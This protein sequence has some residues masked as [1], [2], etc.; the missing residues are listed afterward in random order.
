M[1]PIK[2]PSTLQLVILVYFSQD[3]LL[4]LRHFSG[5]DDSMVWW[6]NWFVLVCSWIIYLLLFLSIQTLHGLVNIYQFVLVRPSLHYLLTAVSE[7]MVA[8]RSSSRATGRSTF[9]RPVEVVDTRLFP[10][11][12]PSLKVTGHSCCRQTCNG[13]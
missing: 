3:N 7:C 8:G 2:D 13:K 4:K 9:P 5:Y 1:W 10:A 6:S 12:E 11:T